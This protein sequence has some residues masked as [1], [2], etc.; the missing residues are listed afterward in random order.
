MEQI[1]LVLLMATGSAG[2]WTQLCGGNALVTVVLSEPP[3]YDSRLFQ[4]HL[5]EPVGV[6]LVGESQV[7]VVR[8]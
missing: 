7:D 8:T 6:V 2:V 4:S 5:L 3:R 1:I